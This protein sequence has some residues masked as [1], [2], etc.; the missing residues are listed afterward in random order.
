MQY[1]SI[2]K[3]LCRAPSS[4]SRELRRAPA[5]SSTYDANL[6]HLQS[7]ARRVMLRRTPK[8]EAGGVLFQV[9]RHY[10]ADSD[11]KCNRPTG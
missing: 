8:L 2:A 6:A 9:V 1:R 7:E 3:C 11:T 4:I 5:G 10:H